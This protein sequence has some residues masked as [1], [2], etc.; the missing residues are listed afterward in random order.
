MKSPIDVK[1][2]KKL[3]VVLPFGSPTP[4]PPF[5][6]RWKRKIESGRVK[7]FSLRIGEKMALRQ[8]GPGPRPENPIRFLCL[9]S[10]SDSQKPAP[11]QSIYFALT[12]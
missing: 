3:G 10:C 4:I 5:P 12:R 8:S 1:G 11:T 6:A 2:S 7:K 9:C